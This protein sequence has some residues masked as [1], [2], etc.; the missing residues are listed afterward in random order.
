VELRAA[1]S[2]SSVASAAAPGVGA[3][4]GR[5]FLAEVHV[6][7]NGGID[8]IRIQAHFIASHQ[9]SIPWLNAEDRASTHLHG[10]AKGKA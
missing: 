6:L 7:I 4:A 5:C 2:S 10:N 9:V 3:A 1:E 8:G